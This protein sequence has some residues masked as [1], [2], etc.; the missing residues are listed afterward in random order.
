MKNKF[1]V[2]AVLLLVIGLLAACGQSAAPAPAESTAGQTESGLAPELSVYNWADYIDESLLT[3]YQEQYGVKIIYDTFAS[4]ED[5]LAKLQ[6]GAAGYD[7]IFPSDYMVSQMIELD[8]LADINQANLP[9]LKNIDPKF[10]AAPYDPTNKCI[11]Y[12]W[13]TT[14]IAY[15]TKVFADNPPDS[16]AYLFD[17]ALAQQWAAAG[18]INLLNDQRELFGAA[19]KYLGYSVN[20]ADEA[21]LQQAKEAILMIKPYV[22]VFNSEGYFE[23]LL[24]PGE[25]V[26]SQAWSGDAFIA[27]DETY[28][29]DT[30]QSDWAYVIPKEGA[31][32]WQDNMC[33]PAASQRQATAE[34]FINFLL[35]PENSAAITNFTFYGSPNQA[36]REFIDPAILEDPAIYPPPEV[37]DKLE[38][39][40]P[41][42]ERVFV[43]DRLWTEIKSQ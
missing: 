11:P 17:P 7:V 40:N 13:G 29:E 16:W 9:N 30:K 32:I 31:V 43:Y 10:L 38:W 3:K 8:L 20:D 25:V 19:L 5:L 18:G 36:A 27:I 2:G 42:G 41:L 24:I 12:Q 34:H 28:N 6:A 35:E 15:S 33:I 37:M 22:K 21:H 4:N 26:I 14:G 23:D 39:M 1:I